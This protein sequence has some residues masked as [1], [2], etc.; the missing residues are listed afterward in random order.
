M[1]GKRP[2]GTDPSVANGLD[3]IRPPVKRSDDAGPRL[4]ESARSCP[5][6]GELDGPGIRRILVEREMRARAVTWLVGNAAADAN[7]FDL[8]RALDKPDMDVAQGKGN[9]LAFVRAWRKVSAPA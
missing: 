2:G 4:E 9:A 3:P 7:G 6:R 1:G 8:D 5:P